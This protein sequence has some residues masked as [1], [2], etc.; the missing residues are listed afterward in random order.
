MPEGKKTAKKGRPD[1]QVLPL[2]EAE[3]RR[4]LLEAL[5]CLWP[6]QEAK[7]EWA[8]LLGSFGGFRGIFYAPPE[9]LERAGVSPK[10]ARYL[11]LTLKLCRAC[12]EDGAG[13]LKRVYDTASAC[14]LLRPQFMGRKTEALAVL[15]LNA[16][17]QVL[18]QGIVTEGSVTAVP[19]YSRRLLELCINYGAY[20]CF[21]AHNHPSDSA[22]PSRNDIVATRQIELALRS[23]DACLQDHI[24]FGGND[25]YSFQESGLLDMEREQNLQMIREELKKARKLEQALEQGAGKEEGGENGV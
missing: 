18:Y 4:L 13:S 23:I 2:Q 6:K 19:I 21:L 16:R 9:E 25:F 14:Q 12:L 11:E 17:G 10:T 1:Q 5:G 8:R 24:I 7:K 15:L 20:S 22:F 3:H